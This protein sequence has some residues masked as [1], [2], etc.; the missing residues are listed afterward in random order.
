MASGEEDP[1]I[2]EEAEDILGLADIIGIGRSEHEYLW[3]AKEAYNADLPGGWEIFFDE[4]GN[5]F[6]FDSKKQISTYTH[7]SI[8]YYRKLYKDFKKKDQEF[9]EQQ[10]RREI[11]FGLRDEE[12]ADKGKGRKSTAGSREG[13]KAGSRAVSPERQDDILSAEESIVEEEKEGLAKTRLLQAY[14]H[15]PN[16]ASKFRKDIR[17]QEGQA[18]AILRRSLEKEEE[19]FVRHLRVYVNQKQESIHGPLEALLHAHT[20]AQ[21]AKIESATR[22]L[23]EQIEELKGQALSAVE[24]ASKA[25]AAAAQKSRATADDEARQRRMKAMQA[26]KMKRVSEE[27]LVAPDRKSVV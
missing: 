21:E 1:E 18:S 11:A 2:D 12:T 19:N 16:L 13:S 8:D 4:E 6:Y 7:P 27:G 20:A 9:R 17:E 15:D 5:H 14:S 3:I 22:L 24:E 25:A 10:E 26:P 23:T